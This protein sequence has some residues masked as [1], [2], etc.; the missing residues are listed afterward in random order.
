MQAI[1]DTLL[2]RHKAWKEAH[3]LGSQDPTIDLNKT[4]GPQLMVD[5]YDIVSRRNQHALP[6]LTQHRMSFLNLRG[7]HRTLAS[8]RRP[9]LRRRRVP[10]L[11]RRRS[12]QRPKSS[13]GTNSRPKS[14][15][16]THGFAACTVTR[17]LEG[18]SEVLIRGGCHVRYLG[19]RGCR[20][21]C[22]SHYG[23]SGM[24]VG[25]ELF[26]KSFT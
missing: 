19:R 23:E 26:C 22:C 15:G 3:A 13:C 24:C 14:N 11:S 8:W 1:M 5:A 21:W 12:N 6:Q 7:Q 4:D 2:E 9:R 20:R 10:R 17:V 16:R 25:P 18:Q